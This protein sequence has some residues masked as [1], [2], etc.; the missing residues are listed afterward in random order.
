[1]LQSDS[2]HTSTVSALKTDKQFSR[3]ES[4]NKP[5]RGGQ[6][7]TTRIYTGERSVSSINTGGKPEQPD[8]KE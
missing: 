1:M 7:M 4:R 5:H 6:F 2:H 3:S 8:A